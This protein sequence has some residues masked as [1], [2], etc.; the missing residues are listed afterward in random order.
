MADV[1][2]ADAEAAPRRKSKLPLILGIVLAL[3]GGGGGFYAVQSGL[4]LGSGGDDAEEAEIEVPPMP[5]VAFVPIDQLVVNLG[6]ESSRRHLRFAAQIEV[7]GAH[8]E[9]VRTLTPRIVD[10]LNSYLRAVDIAEIED[11]SALVRLRAQML[12]RVQLVAGAG[13]VRD[14]LIVEFVVN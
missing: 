4:I 3:A 5:D 12:R 2:T 9:E 8:L 13:R 11:R 7:E 6:G 14:L 1:A 10:V